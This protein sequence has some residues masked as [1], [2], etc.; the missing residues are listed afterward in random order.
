MRTHRCCGLVKIE[1]MEDHYALQAHT[2]QQAYSKHLK[3][4]EQ[5]ESSERGKV[6]ALSTMLWVKNNKPLNLC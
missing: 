5:I 3:A 4:Y 2:R 1:V 6:Q